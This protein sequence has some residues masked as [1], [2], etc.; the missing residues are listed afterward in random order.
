MW[1][2][3]NIGLSLGLSVLTGNMLLFPQMSQWFTLAP[4]F[5]QFL[6][7]SPVL[8]VWS[9]FVSPSEICWLEVKVCDT[10]GKNW[11][12]PGAAHRRRLNAEDS[13][14]CTMTRKRRDCLNTQ[15][16]NKNFSF[17]SYKKV[18]VE[19][20]MMRI[21]KLWRWRLEW[22]FVRWTCPDTTN[23]KETCHSFPTDLGNTFGPVE[24]P[25]YFLLIPGELNNL[26][27]FETSCILEV[28]RGR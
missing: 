25:C 10:G 23:Q 13:F 14:G 4:P 8:S 11:R 15:P 27:T 3:S 1:M 21:C 6:G 18:Q 2:Y 12:S 20:M 24:A 16:V 7:A 26:Q 9:W 19:K 28:S 5:N 17:W 22:M